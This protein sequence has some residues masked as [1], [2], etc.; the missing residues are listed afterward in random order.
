VHKISEVTKVSTDPKVITEASAILIPRNALKK[1]Y[2]AHVQPIYDTE[3]ER[4][5][6][7]S[8]MQRFADYAIVNPAV[9]KD[10]KIRD[11]SFYLSMVEK[12]DVIVFTRFWGFVMAGVGK[13]VQHALELGKEAYELSEKGFKKIE[14]VPE[15]LSYEDTVAF[16]IKLGL[17]KGEKWL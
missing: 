13:E 17:R 7:A 14:T 12:C 8:I 2:F 5:Q 4:A 10:L 3:E 16:F 11:M 6:L 9:V 15:Y 1:V